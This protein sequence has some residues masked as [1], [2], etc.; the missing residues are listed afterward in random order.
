VKLDSTGVS[1]ILLAASILLVPPYAE[2]FAAPRN[3]PIRSASS[4]AG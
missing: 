2:L 3:L 1:G 4:T